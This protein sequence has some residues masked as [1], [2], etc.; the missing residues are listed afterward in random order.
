MQNSKRLI[1]AC[2]RYVVLNFVSTNNFVKDEASS[3]SNYIHPAAFFAAS[4]N[5][6]W[7]Q[8]YDFILFYFIFLII[9]IGC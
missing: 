2:S 8:E 1:E 4:L 6:P 9:V 3:L 7:K 5:D